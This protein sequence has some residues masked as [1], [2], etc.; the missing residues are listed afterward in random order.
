[1]ARSSLLTDT[2]VR[3]LSTGRDGQ[4]FFDFSEIH[5][6]TYEPLFR[7]LQRFAMKSVDAIGFSCD[8]FESLQSAGDPLP[9]VVIS[10][11]AQTK[12]HYTRNMVEL[13]CH[14]VPK[15]R[16]LASVQFSNLTIRR[17]YLERMSVA[18]G[19][20][21]ALRALRFSKVDLYDD[22]L[23]A[24]LLGLNPNVLESVEVTKCRITDGAI[25]DI[26]RFIERRIRIGT[27]LRA[28][29]VSPSEIS[30]PIRRQIE[31]AVSGRTPVDPD[32]QQLRYSETESNG[33]EIE[34]RARIARLR[35][36]NARLA[37]Q[38]RA[39]REMQHAV[40]VTDSIFI[41]GSGAPDFLLYLQD[42]EQRMVAIDSGK[43]M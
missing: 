15:S 8:K 3:Q 23:R 13:L 21:N 14:V 12:T 7:T 29:E 33:G 2:D 28:F 24:V 20:S 37:E 43:W 11:I 30:A 18:F 27:G 41:V 34:R 22:G 4:F 25:E 1:M 31:G 40:K 9:P 16:R 5:A 39:L 35:E 26:L 42:I 32:S 10:S 19:K 36:E 6:D 38:I 17:D